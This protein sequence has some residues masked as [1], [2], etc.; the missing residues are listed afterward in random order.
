MVLGPGDRRLDILKGRD[1]APQRGP[2]TWRRGVN[3][4][5]ISDDLKEE[6]DGSD[7][8]AG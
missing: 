3:L 8:Q 6:E 2:G 1:S 7:R 4:N 5:R